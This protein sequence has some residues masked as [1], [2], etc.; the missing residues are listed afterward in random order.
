MKK[1]VK[2]INDKILDF[3]KN[4]SFFNI[5]YLKLI[6]LIAVVIVVSF[7]VFIGMITHKRIVE[8]VKEDFN[9]QQLILA[10]HGSSQIE[11]LINM[12]K[13]EI[14]LLSLS[15]SVQYFESPG[16]VYRLNITYSTVKDLGVMDLIYIDGNKKIAHKI[17]EEPGYTVLKISEIERKILERVVSEKNRGELILT[18]TYFANNQSIF[19]DMIFPVWQTSIDEAHPVATG[20]FSGVLVFKI[21]VT[22]LVSKVTDKIHSGKTGY[23]WVIDNKG[24]FLYHPE[25]TFIGQNAFKARY[26]REP[27]MSFQQ[28]N[29]LQK[30][31]L[32]GKEGKDWYI[33]GWHRG[34]YGEIE[35]LIAY[36]PITIDNKKGVL[37]SIAVVAPISEIQGTIS[38]IQ[39]QNILL[40]VIIVSSI[41]LGAWFSTL[42]IVK[43][44]NLVKKSEI[45]YRSLIENADDIIFTCDNKYT[46]NSLNKKGLDFFNIKREEDLVG[47]LVSEVF[48]PEGEILIMNIQHV[49]RE[50]EP[51]Q[52][53]HKVIVNNKEFWLNTRLKELHDEKGEIYAVLGISRDI[54]ERKKMEEQSY[55]LEILASLGTLGACVAHEINNP[56][57]VILGFT[58]LLLE[59]TPKESE[60]YEILKIIEKQ[61]L[62]AK[63]SVENLLSFVRRKEHK[64]EL[65]NIN[66]CIITVMRI[67]ENTASINKI[68]IVYNLQDNLPFVKGDAGELQQ[69]FFNIINNAIY[70][71]QN[72]GIL[73]ITTRHEKNWVEIFIADTGPGIKKEYRNRIFEP[74]FTTK[75]VGKGTGLGLWISYNIIEKHDGIIAFKT[76]TKEESEITGTTFVIKLPVTEEENGGIIN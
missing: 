70:A 57:A 76:A 25:K 35:K 53:T 49:F 24:I 65:V 14:Q 26:Q 2:R 52:L 40:Q 13:R 33:S 69:V 62:N 42:M 61:A 47:K 1:L 56:L 3:I 19:I 17:S 67:L 75:E 43:W 66:E 22:Y 8:T 46:L 39:F 38:D 20:K 18:D 55:Y 6:T 45:R 48:S 9:E 54:T 32:E 73:T 41:I 36:T 23:A 72:G 60:Q 44:A 31:M 29:E 7:V 21:D 10:R 71:M 37:W 51:I 12:I 5:I 4:Y 58:D 30:N 16:L 28:I 15:P 34:E 59:K 11:S 64:A 63:I 68:K 50:R 27:T 74:F